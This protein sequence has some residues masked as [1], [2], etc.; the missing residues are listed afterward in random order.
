MRIFNILILI[1]LVSINPANS[2]E[3]KLYEITFKD[4]SE[5]TI[6]LS[7]YKNKVILVVNVASRC[8][9]TKQYKGLQ[10]T[11]EKYKNNGLIILGISSNS[12]NQELDT[13]QEVKNFCESN[14]GIT[15]PVTETV[16]VKGDGA[17]DFYKWALKSHGKSTV[18]KW[19]FYK[20]LIDKNGNIVETYSSMTKPTS[21]KLYRRIEDLL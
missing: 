12:F 10:K 7:D 21:E 6:K 20:I 8:G 13:S 2:M 4:L 11:W 14:F 3:K 1:F 16:N 15:F 5:N 18:P 19:N 9:F 17:H